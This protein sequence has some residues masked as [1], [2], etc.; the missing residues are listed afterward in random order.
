M[1][2]RRNILPSGYWP[3]KGPDDTFDRRLVPMAGP[4]RIRFRALG[5]SSS[6]RADVGVK[7]PSRSGMAMY[8]E[9]LEHR[10]AAGDVRAA[11]SL[12]EG[13]GLAQMAMGHMHEAL[14]TLH[15]NHRC[16]KKRG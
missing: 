12:R 11:M 16:F 15:D 14:D 8:R 6:A 1:L 9:L 3:T 10:M 5:I 2:H 7:R 13:I 4:A